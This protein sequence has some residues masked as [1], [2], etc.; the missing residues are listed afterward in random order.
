MVS[1]KKHRTTHQPAKQ[2]IANSFVRNILPVSD[3]FSIFCRGRYLCREP[4][5]YKY[6]TFNVSIFLGIYISGSRLLQIAC[7]VRSHGRSLCCLAATLAATLQIG[8]AQ[9]AIS[10]ADPTPPEQS[11]AT[12]TAAAGD[13]S[14]PVIASARSLIQQGKLDEAGQALRNYL[15]QHPNSAAAH[16]MLGYTYFQEVHQKSS[17][18]AEKE[19]PVLSDFVGADPTISTA[20]AKASLAEYTEG[21]KYQV[22]NAFDLKVVALDYVL[23][24]DYADADKWLTRSLDANPRDAEA[25]YYLGRAKYNENRFDEAIHAF[26]KYLELDPKSVRGEDNLGLSY[27]GLGRTNEAISAYK[28]AILWQKDLLNQDPGPFINLGALLLDEN[29]LEQAISY[30]V[31][32]VSIAPQNARAHEHLGK[33]YDRLAQPAKAQAELEK[34]VELAPQSARLH[35]VLGQVYRKQGL[36]EKAK[37]EFDRSA[38]LRNGSPSLSGERDQ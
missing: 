11:E 32:A 16:F 8:T 9:T 2:P 33:A 22:P 21:A 38:A 34:A 20:K 31:Q 17:S 26:Q 12:N 6:F 28:T 36:T 18:A 3:L 35:Y 24:R 4:I 25:W 27:Q 37:A 29:Q 10:N 5:Q 14:D 7:E 23:L 15:S 13:K 1:Y 30:L 19:L